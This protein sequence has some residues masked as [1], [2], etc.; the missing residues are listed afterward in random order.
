MRDYAGEGDDDGATHRG[1]DRA[2]PL[3]CG[4]RHGCMAGRTAWYSV[5]VETAMGHEGLSRAGRML[6]AEAREG[7]DP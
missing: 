2:R 7:S 6:G 5:K 4:G 1:W 3:V